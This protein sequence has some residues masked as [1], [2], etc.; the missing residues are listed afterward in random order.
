[1]TPAELQ[2]AIEANT[3]AI[4]GLNQAVSFLVT[5]AIRPAV[6]QAAANYEQLGQLIAIV[7]RNADAISQVQELQA[8]NS[9]QTAQNTQAISS[10]VELVTANQ[11]QIAANAQ[12]IAANTETV[13]ALTELSRNNAEAI[14]ALTGLSRTNT[15]AISTL[16]EG[17]AA[18]DS[19]LEDTRNLVAD[20]AQQQ[21]ITNQ[22]V[23][24]LTE[25]MDAY[26]Q[27]GEAFRE[28]Q[29]EHLRAI[30]GNAQRI[31]RLEQ[32]AS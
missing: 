28:I 29:R 31:D 27:E 9:Q 24:A 5:E 15:E 22:K 23:D 12:Q 19:R 4:A 3:Q 7:E 18:F 26:V 10:L 11:Q 32:Q 25:R 2:Q 14:L 8:G 21:A 16:T 13:T 6:Q 1:M 20:N 30:I 17:I